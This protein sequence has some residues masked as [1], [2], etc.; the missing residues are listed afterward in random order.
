MCERKKRRGSNEKNS[1]RSIVAHQAIA[2][3]LCF[4][5]GCGGDTASRCGMKSKGNGGR[6]A[7]QRIGRKGPRGQTYSRRYT[8]TSS[9]DGKTSAEQ[10]H[11]TSRVARRRHGVLRELVRLQSFTVKLFAMRGYQSNAQPAR[12]SSNTRQINTKKIYIVGVYWEKNVK[13]QNTDTCKSGE[14]SF[15]N[16]GDMCQI[17]FS[18]ERVIASS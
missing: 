16:A 11:T 2:R 12:E 8:Q 7:G 1:S 10:T 13:N 4:E 6:R 5:A 18:R 3:M 15:I 14:A 9:F 17:P